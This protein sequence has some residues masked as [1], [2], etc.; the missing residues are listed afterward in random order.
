[1]YTYFVCEIY[2]SLPQLFHEYSARLVVPLYTVSF[3]CNLQVFEDTQ[4]NEFIFLPFEVYSVSVL[5]LLT[6]T[7]AGPHVFDVIYGTL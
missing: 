1:M 5:T 2:L 4:S 7:N 6:L 3:F